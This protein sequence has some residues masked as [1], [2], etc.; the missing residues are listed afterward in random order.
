MH[1]S[2]DRDS[3]TGV[4]TYAPITAR[5]MQLKR[6]ILLEQISKSV[7]SA[8]CLTLMLRLHQNQNA[9]GANLGQFTSSYS[10]TW[11][12]SFPVKLGV[13]HYCNTLNLC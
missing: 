8:P 12:G 3:T 5:S 6:A 7:T 1:R 2:L 4:H 11:R 13:Y 10:G 9:I